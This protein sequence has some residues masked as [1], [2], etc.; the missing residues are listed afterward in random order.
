[1]FTITIKIDIENP[2]EVA[3]SHMGAIFSGPIGLLP[4]SIIKSKVETKAKSE[5]IKTLEAG[6]KEKFEELGIKGKIGIT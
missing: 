6:L 4:K 3:K 1:M 5:I 2:N